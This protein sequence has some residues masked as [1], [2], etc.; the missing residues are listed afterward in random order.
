[1]QDLYLLRHGLAVPH[2]TPGFED[3]DRPLTPE[4]ER[5]IRQIGRGLRKLGLKLDRIA[6][7]PLPRASRTAELVA[8]SLA[9]PDLV[10]VV[11]ELR[12]GRDAASIRDWLATRG[13]SRLMIVGHDPAFSD[14]VGLLV[15]GSLDRPICE[16]RKG[17]IAALRGTPGDSYLIDW[18]ARPKVF[19]TG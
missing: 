10:E 11:D 2:G 1:M 18:I 6:T 8:D 9:I 14:L 19:R 12:A 7:S 13:E 4:G 17:G 5:R 16:L 15:T 3:D